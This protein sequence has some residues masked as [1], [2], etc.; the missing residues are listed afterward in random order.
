MG[1]MAP[2]QYKS[3]TLLSSILAAAD[4]HCFSDVSPEV[5]TQR[6]WGSRHPNARRHRLAQSSCLVS[7]GGLQVAKRDISSVGSRADAGADTV[8]TRANTPD[9]TSR[10][11]GAVQS[12]TLLDPPRRSWVLPILLLPFHPLS[13][14]APLASVHVSS[15]F[16]LRHAPLH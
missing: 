4:A 15:P 7:D 2:I 16:L 8:R 1:R 5:Q 14:A 3:D 6:Q 9:M 10:P 13:T 11:I 12:A